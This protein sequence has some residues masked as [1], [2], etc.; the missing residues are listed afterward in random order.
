MNETYLEYVNFDLAVRCTCMTAPFVSEL[1]KV[2]ETGISAA[3]GFEYRPLP[4]PLRRTSYGTLKSTLIE[5]F[6]FS[7]SKDIKFS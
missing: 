6:G 5:Y 1:L 2:G 3:T 7:A 4:G